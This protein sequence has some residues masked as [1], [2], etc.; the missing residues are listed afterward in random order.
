MWEMLEIIKKLNSAHEKTHPFSLGFFEVNLKNLEENIAKIKI[1]NSENSKSNSKIK[2][3][4]PVKGGGYGCGMK[5]ISYFVQ[6]KKCVDYLGVAHIQEAFELREHGITLPI[7]VLGQTSYSEKFLDFIANNNIEIAV[8]EKNTINMIEKH[9]TQKRDTTKISVH[10]KIDL[11]M[12]RCGILEEN[13]VDLF[14]RILDSNCVNIKGVMMHFPVSDSDISE[15]ENFEYTEIQIQKFAKMKEKIKNICTQQ[16]KM[17]I[18]NNIIF[19]A[20][21]SGASTEHS[22]ATFDMIRPGI[23]SY[24]Y[25]EP[26][27]GAEKLQLKPVAKVY[28]QFSLI[29]KFPEKFSIGYGRTYYTKNKNEK[30]G[31]LPIGYA[32]GLNRLLSNNFSIFSENGEEFS[33]SGRISMDQSAY[34]IRNT[35]NLSEQNIKKQKVYIL[36]TNQNA[37]AIAKK[38]GTISYEVLLSLGTSDRLKKV[39]IWD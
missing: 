27:N 7:L 38:I 25:P 17:N 33:C 29:K 22:T 20:A 16:N 11:G 30:I 6:E 21:N 24:G 35:Q 9:Y 31:M 1:K 39:Y 8:S 18:F 12:G 28:S 2:Y 3:L 32:D 23:A 19:H 14:Q 15:K 4:L 13:I 5:E 37:R 26:G 10:L 36:G 34:T